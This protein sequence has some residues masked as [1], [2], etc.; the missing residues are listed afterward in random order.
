MAIRNSQ[1]VV[2]L[3]RD[4][5]LAAATNP[6]TGVTASDVTTVV[7]AAGST[8]NVD[9]MFMTNRFTVFEELVFEIAGG[10]TASGKQFKGDQDFAMQACTLARAVAF[11]M[12][13]YQAT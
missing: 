2:L 1:D 3:T 4:I 8:R 6:T 13:K 10:F 7:V 5:P 11:E 9:N 12:Q